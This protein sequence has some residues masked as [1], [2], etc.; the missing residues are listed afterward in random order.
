MLVIPNR[1]PGPFGI[2]P[3]ALPEVLERLLELG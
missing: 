1:R 2:A 3:G